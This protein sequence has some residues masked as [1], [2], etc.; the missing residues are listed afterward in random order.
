MIGEEL[1]DGL[2][3]VSLR[4]P[5]MAYTFQLDVLHLVPFSFVLVP[6]LARKGY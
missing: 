5:H 2:I 1:P 6:I 4:S 3:D